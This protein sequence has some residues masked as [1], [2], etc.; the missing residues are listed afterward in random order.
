MIDIN[1]TSSRF[2]IPSDEFYEGSFSRTAIPYECCFAHWFDMKRKISED[3]LS[4]IVRKR[5][6]IN[7]DNSCLMLKRF[8]GRIGNFFWCIIKKLKEFIDVRKFFGGVFEKFN[9][10]HDNR[11]QYIEDP[12]NGNEIT[13]RVC[14]INNS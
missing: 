11:I 4:I 9:A 12:K 14:S 2:Q 10:I 3:L 13:I 5:D 1:L 6:G 8:P 7:R